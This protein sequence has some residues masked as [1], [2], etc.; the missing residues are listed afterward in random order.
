M[1]GLSLPSRS[2]ALTTTISA[3]CPAASR[4]VLLLADDAAGQAAEMVVVSA[5]DRLGN[6]SPRISVYKR[7]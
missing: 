2:T 1:R 5:V 4:A 3:A 6:E 7:G